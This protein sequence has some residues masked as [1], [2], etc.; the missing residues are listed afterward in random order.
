MATLEREEMLAIQDC[1][2]RLVRKANE[3]N[4]VITK[5]RV[6]E[7]K[8]TKERKVHQVIWHLMRPPALA[9]VYLARKAKVDHKE[10]AGQQDHSVLKAHR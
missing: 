7:S 1:L 5:Y 10:T 3:V 4:P 2:E 6:K 8:V 9:P